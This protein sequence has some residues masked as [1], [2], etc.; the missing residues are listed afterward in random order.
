MQL[1]V[2]SG[3]NRRSVT[4]PS[5]FALRHGVERAVSREKA[6]EVI[7]AKTLRPATFHQSL[8]EEI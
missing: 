5:T 6:K 8:L 7:L 1:T 3:K 2:G 4:V